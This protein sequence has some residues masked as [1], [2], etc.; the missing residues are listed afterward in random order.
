MPRVLSLEITFLIVSSFFIY[1]PISSC[2][3]PHSRNSGCYLTVWDD[4]HSV[5]LLNILVFN[6]VLGTVL[7]EDLCE[8]GML[9]H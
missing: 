4:E 5:C 7:F 3:S 9:S 6:V 2:L 8:A 1:S